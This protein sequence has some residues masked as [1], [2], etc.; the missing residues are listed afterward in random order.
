MHA[1][2]GFFGALGDTG[3]LCYVFVVCICTARFWGLG[4]WEGGGSAEDLPWVS[5]VR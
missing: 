2:G 3:M 1:V 4:S 5:K